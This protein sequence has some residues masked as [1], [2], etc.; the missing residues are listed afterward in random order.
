MPIL[1]KCTSLDSGNP[2]E[3]AREYRDLIESPF[4]FLNILGGCCGTDA[5]HVRA[6][7]ETCQPLFLSRQT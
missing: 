4:C 5:R 6:I 3:L 2:A 7:I 1:E